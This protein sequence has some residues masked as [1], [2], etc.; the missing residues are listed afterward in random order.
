MINFL[1]GFFTCATIACAL[2]VYVKVANAER[3]K[4]P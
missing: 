2:F 4:Y 3:R 1:I